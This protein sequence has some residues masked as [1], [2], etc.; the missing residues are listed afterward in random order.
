MDDNQSGGGYWCRRRV[1]TRETTLDIVKEVLHEG[2]KA[3]PG[4]YVYS[5]VHLEV[6]EVKALKYMVFIPK[7]ATGAEAA[8]PIRSRSVGMAANFDVMAVVGATE[9]AGLWAEVVWA[10]VEVW[11]WVE[12]WVELAEGG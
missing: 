7:G 11:G 9:A 5:A 8:G 1:I 10:S 4:C 3:R 2:N 12:G 6:K